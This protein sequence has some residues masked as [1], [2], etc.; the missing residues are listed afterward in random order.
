MYRVTSNELEGGREKDVPGA[1][2]KVIR[3]LGPDDAAA[4]V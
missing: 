3:Y 1:F 2:S 4:I